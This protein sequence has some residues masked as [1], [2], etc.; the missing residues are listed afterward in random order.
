MYIYCIHNRLP[1]V[2]PAGS[3]HVEDKKKIKIKILIWEM[4]ILYTCIRMHGARNM[5]FV[6]SIRPWVIFSEEYKKVG[7]CC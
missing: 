1:E 7:A 4:C 2:E 3:K 5:K 6:H